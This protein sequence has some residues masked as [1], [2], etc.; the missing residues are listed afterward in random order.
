[1]PLGKKLLG[2]LSGGLGAAALA[3]SAFAGFQTHR[4]TE[5][6]GTVTTLQ[7]SLDRA[8][9]A[10]A[11]VV[12]VANERAEA[13]KGRDGIIRSQSDSIDALDRAA[14]A[15]RSSYLAGI[16]KADAGGKA[17]EARADE[18]IHMPTPAPADRCEAARSLILQEMRNVR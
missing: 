17:H 2:Y 5:S 9:K 4:L 10:F 8:D 16:R 6:K 3:T 1:M 15:D 18:L 12:L 13:L 11:T 7:G 14:Q